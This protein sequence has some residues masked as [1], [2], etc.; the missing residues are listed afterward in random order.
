[1]AKG[2]RL[3]V[4]VQHSG[5]LMEQTRAKRTASPKAARLDIA[6]GQSRQLR[7]VRPAPPVWG[8]RAAR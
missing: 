1:M 8:K 5:D 7:Q 4:M 2:G 3:V 6:E